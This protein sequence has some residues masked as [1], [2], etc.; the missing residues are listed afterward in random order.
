MFLFYIQVTSRTMTASRIRLHCSQIP[1]ARL[2]FLV[3]SST[4]TNIIALLSEHMISRLP[5]PIPPQRTGSSTTRKLPKKAFCLLSPSSEEAS[6]SIHGEVL[7]LCLNSAQPLLPQASVLCSSGSSSHAFR[8]VWMV[9]ET[10]VIL[11]FWK[12]RQIISAIPGWNGHSMSSRIEIPQEKAIKGGSH[13]GYELF[14]YHSG[15]SRTR[16]SLRSCPSANHHI[17]TF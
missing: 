17:R 11:S 2:Q 14:R 10:S 13:T 6:S 8:C 7:N 15:A 16:N 12:V 3:A 1:T 5:E 9:Q 4:T